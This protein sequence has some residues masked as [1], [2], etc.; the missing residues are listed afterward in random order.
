MPG[1]LI[2]PAMGSAVITMDLGLTAGGSRAMVLMTVMRGRLLRALPP[3]FW[4]LRVSRFCGRGCLCMLLEMIFHVTLT[5]VEW[6][7]HP[8]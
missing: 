7:S 5:S 2:V 8:F 1:V 4:V 6:I 3:D